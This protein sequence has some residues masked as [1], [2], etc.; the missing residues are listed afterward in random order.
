MVKKTNI[1]KT[2]SVLVLRVLIAQE[3]FIK[4]VSTPHNFL[5]HNN[6]A[7]VKSKS[8]KTVCMGKWI[9]ASEFSFCLEFLA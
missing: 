3:N 4:L 7:H 8:F 5:A 9:H 1:L 6:I 2:I